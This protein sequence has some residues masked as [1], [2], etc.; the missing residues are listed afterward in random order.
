MAI[1]QAAALTGFVQWGIRQSAEVSNQLMSVER[2]LEYKVLPKEKQPIVHQKPP[3]DWPSNGEI[4]FGNM[5]LKYV[6]SGTL[7]LRNLNLIIHSN[8][9]VSTI[10]C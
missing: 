2:V 8:E 10:R 9:K 4:K 6:D 3:K 5:G 1:T 7:V